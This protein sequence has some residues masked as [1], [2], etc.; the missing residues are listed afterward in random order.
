MYRLKNC[1]RCSG[2]LFL[3]RDEYG[4]FEMCIQCG[5]MRSMSCVESDHA[6]EIERRIPVYAQ[7]AS[8]VKM[9]ESIY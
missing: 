8:Q 6:A 1:P 3:D 7:P 9:L 4:W 5:H 2:D